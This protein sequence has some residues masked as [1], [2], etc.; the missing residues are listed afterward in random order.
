MNFAG[1]RSDL[2][3]RGRLYDFNSFMV[4]FRIYGSVYLWDLLSV[5]RIR[6][7]HLVQ[8]IGTFYIQERIGIF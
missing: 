2:S 6:R 4:R 1:Q 7:I 8:G 3:M 5:R